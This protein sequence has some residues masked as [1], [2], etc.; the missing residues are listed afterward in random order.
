MKSK[1]IVLLALLLL[2]GCID[3]FKQEVQPSTQEEELTDAM[4]EIPVSLENFDD[5]TRYAIKYPFKQSIQRLDHEMYGISRNDTYEVT[6]QLQVLS[7]QYFSVDDYMVGEGQVL[8]STQ[9]RNVL[10]FNSENYPEGLNPNQDEVFKTEQNKEVK[11]PILVQ[12]LYEMNFYPK[13][14]EE[15]EGIAF[16]IALNGQVSS[17]TI[18]PDSLPKDDLIEYGENAARKLVSYVRTLDNM[19]NI[20]IFVAIYDLASMD[21]V[22]PGGFA[23]YGFFESNSSQFTKINHS[24]V[25]LPSNTAKQQVPEEATEFELMKSNVETFLEQE[26]VGVIGKARLIN[27]KVNYL[28]VTVNTSGKTYLEV[29]GLA[30]YISLQLQERFK[31]SDFPI[32]VEIKADFETVMALERNNGNILMMEW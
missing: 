21:S 12:S 11:Q 24:W 32:L 2:V 30:Q 18:N 6:K 4:D 29:Q 27:N 8:N 20:P 28:Q 31:T 7:S 26:K 13:N 10:R 22:V 9:F 5:T 25:V 15:L 23:S 19:G 1:L 16:A 14:G 3:G 17:N